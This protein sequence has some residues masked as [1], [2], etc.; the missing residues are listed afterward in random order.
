MDSNENDVS[1]LDPKRLGARECPNCPG[2]KLRMSVKTIAR[3]TYFCELICLRCSREALSDPVPR[4][5]GAMQQ[6]I[7]RWNSKWCD[8]LR[9]HDGES[10][11]I[12]YG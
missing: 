4:I 7:T 6:V 9:W 1:Q 2:S 3:G 5:P 10:E 12:K 11:G 8:I